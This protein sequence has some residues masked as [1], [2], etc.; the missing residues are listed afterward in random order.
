ML[1]QKH[2]RL[3]LGDE[4]TSPKLS[5]VINRPEHTFSTEILG[6]DT[7]TFSVDSPS[8]TSPFGYDF[9]HPYPSHFPGQFLRQFVSA[10]DLP[11]TW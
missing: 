1:P 11:S 7:L 3:E 10:R 9:S 6:N 2:R 4:T 8:M 5:Y